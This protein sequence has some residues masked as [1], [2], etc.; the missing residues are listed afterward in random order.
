MKIMDKPSFTQPLDHIRADLFSILFKIENM[1]DEDYKEL[2]R[3]NI[4]QR[5]RKLL[6]ISTKIEEVLKKWIS[7]I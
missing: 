1:G 2:M 4:E 7:L 3:K 6:I 5:V